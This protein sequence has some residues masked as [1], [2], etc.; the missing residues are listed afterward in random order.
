MTIGR[1]KFSYMS[2]LSAHRNKFI[3]LKENE[4]RHFLAECSWTDSTG[5]TIFFRYLSIWNVLKTLFVKQLTWLTKVKFVFVYTIHTYPKRIMICKTTDCCPVRYP[6]SKWYYYDYRVVWPLCWPGSIRLCNFSRVPSPT[7][8]ITRRVKLPRR[9]SQ[10]ELFG[11][12]F[13]FT[14]RSAERQ[15][16]TFVSG[17]SI[18]CNVYTVIYTYI[19][20]VNLFGVP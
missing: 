8:A 14:F 10:R 3:F 4:N 9:R 5:R 19:Y 1:T 6:S 7:E 18:K 17:Q 11:D 13:S 2:T 15:I 16:I 20:I 12:R